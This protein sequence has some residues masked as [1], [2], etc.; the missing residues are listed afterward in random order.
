MT[1]YFKRIGLI[2]LFTFPFL[3]PLFLFW[4]LPL[5]SAGYISFTDWD[6]IKPAFNFVGFENY[7]ML[8]KNQDFYRALWKTCTFSLGVI[9]PTI[10]LGFLT[11][12]LLQKQLRGSALY[13]M[14]I[15]SPWI[16]P[17]VAVSIVWS[18]IFDPDAGFANYLL[19]LMHQPGLEWLK[20]S[21]TAMLSVIIITVWKGLGWTMLFYLGALEKVPESVYEAADTDGANYFQTLTQVTIPLIS[22]TTLF[23]VVVNL[24]NTVQAFDQIKVLTQGG[25][26]GSTRTLLYMYYQSAFETFEAG[27]ASAISIVIL[28]IIVGASFINHLISKKWIYY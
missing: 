22:P 20:S 19:S 7:I 1:A 23:L 5:F 2:L 6:M 17:M 3:I 10:V 4:I 25:P 18:W 24:I 27:M 21:K 15:F 11:S 12:L 8:L 26:A 28:F 9:I 13:K 16:T 14:I